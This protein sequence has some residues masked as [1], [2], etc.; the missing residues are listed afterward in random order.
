MAELARSLISEGFSIIATGGTTKYLREQ[1]IECEYVRKVHEGR[2]HIVDEMKNGDIALVF[3]T[4]SGKQSLKDSFSLR[5]T[6][7]TQKIPYFTTAAAARAS[8][9]AIKAIRKGGYDVKSLQDIA[10]Q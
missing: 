8:V 2:P 10:A 7:L 5:R 3:N 4:T 1:G 6:A 9:E